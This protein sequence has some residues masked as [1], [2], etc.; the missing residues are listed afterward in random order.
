[1]VRVQ[2]RCSIKMLQTDGGEFRVLSTGL[3]HLGI[4]HRI[5]CP[6]TSEQNGVVER[7][8]RQLIDMGLTLLAQVSLP[9]TFWSYAFAHAVH[10][11]N[12]LPTP[13][14]RKK[15]PYEL[16]YKNCPDYSFLWRYVTFDE[17]LFPFKNRF[18]LPSAS[19]T[20]C[21]SRHK[22]PLPLVVATVLTNQ[23]SSS[24]D[25]HISSPVV[26]SIPSILNQSSLGG[27][28]V[29]SGE[30][31]G[32]IG[33]HSGFSGQ[34][35]FSSQ[36]QPTCPDV[37]VP[38]T[39]THPMQTRSKSGS[40]KLK[41]LTSVITEKEP[42]SITEAF[43]SPA[44]LVNNTWDLVPLPE[45]RRAVSC[46]WI[47]KVKRH[48][49]GSVARYKGRLVVK[50]YLQETLRQVDINNAFLNGDLQEEIYMMQPPGFEQQGAGS[51]HLVYRLKKALYGLKQAPRAWF[52]KLRDFLFDAQFVVS[53]ADTSLFIRR[54]P[55]GINQFVK[56]LDVRFSLKD[57]GRL[58]YFLGIEVSYTSDGLF[59][60]Q[61]KYILDLLTRA[62][63]AKCNALPTPMV[64]T[65][66]LSAHEGTPVD[67]PHLYKSLVGALQYVVITRPDIL[68][69]VNK[70]PWI[71]V[72]HSLE[73]QS[74]CLKV[75]LI[76]VG[77]PMPMIDIQPP[78]IAFFLGE[79]QCL[80]VPENNRW[81]TGLLLRRNIIALLMS[82]PKCS[83]AVALAENSVM[84]SKFKYVELDL[85]FV[86]EKVA[87]GLF[88]V[89]HVPSQE[90]TTDALTK[91]LSAGLFQKFRSQLQ[92]LPIHST[93]PAQLQGGS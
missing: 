46:K 29:S 34:L 22:S 45:N 20:T 73:G 82:L 84:H 8:Y 37:T 9:L 49:D 89:G 92:I 15:S 64:T 81:S 36:P 70:E 47:F 87:S 32:S 63:M 2:F 85:Y 53:K 54:D 7:K 4:Q 1:M 5:T 75:F 76:L 66:H 62:S 42:T 77:G 30:P 18:K 44:L 59:F 28:F 14:L 79:I 35:S 83:A 3:A 88:Q 56:E 17:S 52:H 58:G 25:Q 41:L 10:L 43:Q 27:H 91:P 68:F 26:G 86:Q 93:G 65:C 13:V 38:C 21:P 80:G 57:L 16:L 40:F 39:N 24:F 74:F 67:E 55:H 12:R 69:S 78:A 51:Q 23:T 90:Q 33:A 11:I 71:M 60:S 19:P 61:R 48:A 72:S 31:I 50:G 6:H